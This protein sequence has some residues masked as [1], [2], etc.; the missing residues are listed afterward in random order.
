MMSGE[1]IMLVRSGAPAL[2]GE[3]AGTELIPQRD[4]VLQGHSNSPQCLQGEGVKEMESQHCM[5]V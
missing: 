5:V 1:T 2:Q 4:D 3:T